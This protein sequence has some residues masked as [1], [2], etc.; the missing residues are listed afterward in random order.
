LFDQRAA[1]Y[2]AQ[3][4]SFDQKIAAT[5]TTIAKFEADEAH[6][7]EREDIAKQIED[8]RTTLLQKGAGSLLN[9]LTSTDS[10]VEALRTLDFGHNSLIE[11]QHQLSSLQADREAFVQQWKST[12]SQDL[13]TA[14]NTRDGARNQLEKAMKHQELVRLVAPEASMVLTIARLNVG[15]VLKEGDPLMTLVPLGAPLQAEVQIAARDVGFMR[16]GDPVTLKIDAFNFA[17]HG[18]ATGTVLWISEGAFTSSE[19]TGAAAPA[20]Y[21]ARIAIDSVNLKDVPASFRLIPGMT[22]TADVK[23]GTRA[24][25]AYILGG[26]ITGVGDAMREP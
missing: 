14:R 8:M 3:L 15:S 12:A 21:K 22:L 10:R 23:V 7:K 24:L 16:A 17:E 4:N 6:F 20:Y 5:Q 11:A 18:T 25:G 1:Q 19:D 13:V 26:M 9:L 2:A